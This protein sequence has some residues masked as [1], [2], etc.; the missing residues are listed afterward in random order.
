[1]CPEKV[2][3]NKDTQDETEAKKTRPDQRTSTERGEEE[4][5]EEE[6]GKNSSRSLRSLQ[7]GR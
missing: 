4:D 6:T 3:G 2:R 5:V 7:V 1:M